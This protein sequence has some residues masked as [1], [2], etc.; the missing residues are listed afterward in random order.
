[1]SF[2]VAVVG[3]PFLD[4]T[5]AGLDR[6]PR[7]GEEV[8]GTDLHIAPGGTGM[9]AIG[10]ARLGLATALVAPLGTSN[11]AT[12]LKD[13]LTAEGVNLVGDHDRS[14]GVPVTALLTTGE[15]V[16]MA[17]V[18]EGAEPS[19]EEVAGATASAFILSLGR[20]RLGP[21]DAALYA[22]TGSLELGSV[23]EETMQ[24][25]SLARAFIV[26][27]REAEA[28][29]GRADP[30][31]A[32]RALAELVATAIVTMG[33]HGAVAAE[34]KQVISVP[35]PRVDAVD[36][37]GAGDLFVAAYVWA[38]LRGAALLDRLEWASLYAGLSTRAPTARA[39][40]LSLEELLSE[41]AA[42]GLTTPPDLSAL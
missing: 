34:G 22:C 33:S 36:A 8:V 19:A 3:A 25:L 31:G 35:A 4:L 12:L 39:G 26:N 27:A 9:Q 2:D 5:F 17:S 38:D 41:G 40:A 11:S 23:G 18:I 30:E 1:V 24:G 14:A 21:S 15:G 7:I 32:A 42:R 6:L 20:L 16:A 13:M 28:L 29:T 37:T 10:A